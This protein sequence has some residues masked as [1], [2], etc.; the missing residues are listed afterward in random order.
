LVP[1]AGIVAQLNLEQLGRTDGTGKPRQAF[2][3]G[4]DYSGLPDIFAEAAAGVGIRIQKD[5]RSNS[6]FDHSDNLALAERGIPAHTLSVTYG[7][8]DYHKVTDSA[9]KL[10]YENLALVTRG[11]ALGLLRLGSEAEPPKWNEKYRPAARYVEAAR[12]LHAAP[13]K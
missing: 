3:T 11:I 9:E 13:V 6:Y 7:Y 4:F 8:P 2:I 10:D 1:L 12:K 5:R